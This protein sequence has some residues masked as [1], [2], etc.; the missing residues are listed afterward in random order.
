MMRGQR[1]TGRREVRFGLSEPVEVAVSHAVILAPRRRQV[2]ANN[3]MGRWGI[4]YDEFWPW[5]PI[6]HL[7]PTPAQ[8]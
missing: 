5:L 6:F 7:F 1:V 8:P 3:G 2:K 4:L